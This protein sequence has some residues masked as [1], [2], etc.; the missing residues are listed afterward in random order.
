ME[1][2]TSCDAGRFRDHLF[3][4]G[5]SSSSVKRIFSTVRAVRNLTIKEHGLDRSN[6]FSGTFI[7]DDTRTVKR[8]PVPLDQLIKIQKECFDIDDEARWLIAMISDIGMRLS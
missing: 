4:R 5:M 7:P 1:E 8:K 6:V 3:E 2:I